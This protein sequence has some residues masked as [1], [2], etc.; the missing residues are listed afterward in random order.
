M[1][2][3][4]GFHACTS[5]NLTNL[6]TVQRLNPFFTFFLAGFFLKEKLHFRK[7]PFFILV[8]LGGLLVTMPGFRIDIFPALFALLSAICLSC[9]HI[10]LRYLRLTNHYLVIINYRAC[11]IGLVSFIVLFIQN[12]FD[13]PGPSDLSFLVLLG[14]AALG[15]QT[16]LTKTYQL[17]PAS[18]VSLYNYSQII[19]AA[20]LT[21]I[22]FREFSDGLS[23]AG[24]GLIIIKGT[25]NY[26]FRSNVFTKLK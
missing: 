15:A 20:I 19:F 14:L 18:L 10:T 16:S 5:M 23:I 7:I 6:M 9:S 21:M 1:G 8:F 17:A 11:I 26:H 4:S 22:L 25:L 13:L 24:V 12:D 2:T 3:F